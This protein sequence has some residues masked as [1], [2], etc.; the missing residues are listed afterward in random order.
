MNSVACSFFERIPD[1]ITCFDL[2][3][4]NFPFFASRIEAKAFFVTRAKE[5]LSYTVTVQL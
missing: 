1:S 2:G 5:T 3:Y 4:M